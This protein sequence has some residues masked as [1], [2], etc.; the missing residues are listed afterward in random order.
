[1][2][3]M[4][5]LVDALVNAGVDLEAVPHNE[6]VKSTPIL[7]AASTS[8][9]WDGGAICA[10]L[11]AGADVESPRDRVGDTGM[12]LPLLFSLMS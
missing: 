7:Q 1:M 3:K 4:S 11:A 8:R 9:I 2:K 12:N 10:M 5:L 6:G